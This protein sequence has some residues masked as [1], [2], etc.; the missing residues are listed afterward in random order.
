MDQ[1]STRR[2]ARRCGLVEVT[3]RPRDALL[4]WAPRL[5][6]RFDHHHTRRTTHDMT[7]TETLDTFL[8]RG[9]DVAYLPLGWSRHLTEELVL[10]LRLSGASRDEADVGWSR[11]DLPTSAREH[12]TRDRTRLT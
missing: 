2:P 5:P 6:R 1:H 7:R 11:W 4:Q 8:H 12:L 10:M 9:G 3:V